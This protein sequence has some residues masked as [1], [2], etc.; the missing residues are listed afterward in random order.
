MG[1]RK[2]FIIK[3]WTRF[4]L[5]G[6]HLQCKPTVAPVHKSFLLTLHY[7]CNNKKLAAYF[8]QNYSTFM[9][10]RILL[11]TLSRCTY[12][13]CWQYRFSGRLLVMLF[14]FRSRYIDID[15]ESFND[16]SKLFV[17]S[18]I[19]PHLCAI[20]W[21][22]VD[23]KDV[24]PYFHI[25]LPYLAILSFHSPNVRLRSDLTFKVIPYI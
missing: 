21:I 3:S 5:L 8:S 22:L 18:L 20:T 16:M 9:F 24:L 13:V 6:K 17:K 7:W 2:H 19:F 12:E 23:D 11:L 25:S 1:C 10:I 14:F 15:I 4:G